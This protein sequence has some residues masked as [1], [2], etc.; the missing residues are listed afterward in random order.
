MINMKKGFTLIEVLVVI[1]I[2]GILAAAV[3]A[4]LDPIEQIKKTR[5][6]TTKNTAQELLQ[7]FLRYNSAFGTLPW[8][9]TTP[10]ANNIDLT[11][12]MSVSA[13]QP[14]ID[15]IIKA[16]E[17][18]QSF[19]S[20]LG[21]TANKMYVFQTDASDQTALLVCFRPESKSV[22]LEKNT[23]FDFSSGRTL[24][25]EQPTGRNLCKEDPSNPCY[26]CA[27]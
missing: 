18:K 16:G 5:D 2:I 27:R 19:L 23:V 24:S 8:T 3:L 9:D 21:D 10:C 26:W 11:T 14:C 4:I 17:L 6:N 1:A 7:A 25:E 12:A 13:L 15:K 20:Q 22:R